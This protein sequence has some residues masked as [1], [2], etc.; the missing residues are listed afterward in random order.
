MRRT[1]EPGQVFRYAERDHEETWM[2]LEDP[3]VRGD[4]RVLMLE[5]GFV[6]EWT[7]DRRWRLDET[8]LNIERIV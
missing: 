2:I 8:Y 6:M 7:V 4:Y 3:D 5:L 1:V